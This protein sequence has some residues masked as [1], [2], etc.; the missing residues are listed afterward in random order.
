MPS[1]PTPNNYKDYFRALDSRYERLTAEGMPW[2]WPLY[3]LA[4]RPGLLHEVPT[5][6]IQ[7]LYRVNF[8][9]QI[10]LSG[11]SLHDLL[12]WPPSIEVIYYWKCLKPIAANLRVLVHI[13]NTAGEIAVQ[14]DH[15]PLR[16]S[17]PTTAWKGR[18]RYTRAVRSSTAW[19]LAIREIPDLGR[20][21]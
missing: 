7:H 5:G 18:R 15:W 13:T 4:P 20:L 14:Q 19:L 11:V 3:D 12:G 1:S 21:V 16:G 8:G 2:A 10:E 9:D 17:L 6:E